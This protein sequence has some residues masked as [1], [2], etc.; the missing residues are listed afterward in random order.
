MASLKMFGHVWIVVL[1]VS[2]GNFKS[3]FISYT[4]DSNI[5]LKLM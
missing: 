1:K 4:C 5:R 2:V 3:D